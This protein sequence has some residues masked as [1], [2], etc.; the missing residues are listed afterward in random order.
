MDGDSLEVELGLPHE[1]VGL[2]IDPF[3][4]HLALVSPF[5]LSDH[6]F[7]AAAAT[8]AGV[9]FSGYQPALSVDQFQLP[10]RADSSTESVDTVAQLMAGAADGLLVHVPGIMASSRLS[11]PAA[12]HD[13]QLVLSRPVAAGSAHAAAAGVSQLGLAMAPSAA[14]AAGVQP[15]ATATAQLPAASNTSHVLTSQSAC[16]CE[17]CVDIALECDDIHQALCSGS[18]DKSLT[19]RVGEQLAMTMQG[20]GWR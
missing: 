20:G 1:L 18:K 6:F 16:M 17:A 15:T 14:T 9:G 2:P 13:L 5:D 11:Q 7:S 4:D 3:L 10:D 19:Q 12:A 8:E